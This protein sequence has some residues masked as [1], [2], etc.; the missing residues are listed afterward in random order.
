MEKTL[1]D[2][3]S[4][5]D[6]ILHATLKIIGKEGFQSI[7]IKK[8]ADLAEVNIAA[9]NYH[10]GSKTNVIHEAIKVLNGK[11]MRCFEVLERKDIPAVERLRKFLF[12][13]MESA[14]EYPDI[15]RSV[16]YSA[17]N[18]CLDSS[19]NIVLLREE[20]LE[21]I[22][23]TIQEAGLDIDNEV[24]MMKLVQIIGCTQLPILLGG[25]MKNLSGIDF[26][27]NEIINKY[28]EIMLKSLLSQ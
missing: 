24:L 12:H 15:F 16:I 13:Y 1:E 6:K 2:A 22:K 4:T 23:S 14:L 21:K 18:N 3:A 25:H 7:T 17:I 26:N 5:R 28:V 20:S 27:E 9:V 10:F 11:R 19:D 8:I